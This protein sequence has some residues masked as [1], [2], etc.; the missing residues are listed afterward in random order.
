MLIVSKYSIHEKLRENIDCF[1]PYLKNSIEIKLEK[2]ELS[3]SL[4]II[5]F[6]KKI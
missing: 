1:Y 3:E 6:C 2:L 4:K 5:E